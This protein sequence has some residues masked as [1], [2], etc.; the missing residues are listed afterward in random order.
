MTVRCGNHGREHVYHVSPAEV[1]ACFANRQD[2]DDQARQEP[3]RTATFGAQPNQALTNAEAKVQAREQT[4]WPEDPTVALNERTHARG[5]GWAKTTL[6]LDH[7]P[8]GGY[9]LESPTDGRL[10]FL[11]VDRPEDG[12]W[13]DFVFVKVRASDER[14]KLGTVNPRYGTYAGKGVALVTV[15]AGADTHELQQYAIRF[16]LELGEC[17]FCRRSLTDED[18]RGLGYGP[19]CAGRHGLYHPR[20][21]AS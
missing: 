3:R 5:D 20:A 18:S 2:F 17:G 12:K 19:V 13:K 8:E 4:L 1:R 21:R 7:V 6:K 10:R 9:A 14:H 16:G 11:E 15:L